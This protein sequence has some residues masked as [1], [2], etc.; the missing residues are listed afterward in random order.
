MFDVVYARRR[1]PVELTDAVCRPLRR[2]GKITL[3]YR[4]IS[5]S[6]WAR[7]RRTLFPDTPEVR[8]KCGG[9]KVEN[10]KHETFCFMFECSPSLALKSPA[11]KLE[12]CRDL[13]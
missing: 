13:T 3:Q 9:E 2:L 5:H 10:I 1:L 7:R 6:L 12:R 11:E 4:E 8:E